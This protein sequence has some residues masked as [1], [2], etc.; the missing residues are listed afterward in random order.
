MRRRSR[1]GCRPKPSSEHACPV[2]AVLRCHRVASAGAKRT[3][4]GMSGVSTGHAV[5]VA[6]RTAVGSAMGLGHLGRCLALAALRAVAIESFVL[7]DSD[8]RALKLVMTAGFQGAQV[9]CGDARRATVE[10]CERLGAGAL[11]VDSYAFSSDDLR[12]LVA[13]GWPVIVFDDTA[14]RELPVDLVINGGAGAG[15]LAYRGSPHT[16]Y[17]LGPSYL[18]LRPEFGE[19]GPRTI[20]D[21]VRRALLTSG[22]ADPDRLTARLVRWTIAGFGAITLDVVV[23]PLVAEVDSI[24]AV[25]RSV[26]G[27]VI[28]HESPKQLHD[29]M[30]AGDLAI[31]GGGQTL[32]ELAAL[33]TPMVAIHLAE[34]QRL[35]IEAM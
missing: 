29:L 31:T 27:R 1:R 26:P 16:R 25:V 9:A 10:C 8:D 7:L 28:L 17:L 21:H 13:A 4:A 30:L 33:G 12:A 22:G 18:A 24:R 20:H 14:T 15:R 35:N 5:R 23:G 6:F 2:S 19:A 34:N 3:R 11:V 32:Y